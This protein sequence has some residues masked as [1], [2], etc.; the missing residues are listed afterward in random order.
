MALE[1]AN[2]K[3]IPPLTDLILLIG[4]PGAGKSTFARKLIEQQSLDSAAHISNDDIAKELFGVT[5]DRGDKD[6][7]VF[8]EQDKRIA[9]RLK[10]GQVAIVDATN[11]KPEAR[12]RLIAIAKQYN[13][14]VTALCFY[15]D[16]AT[17]LKQ[18]QGR[19]VTVPE[20]MVREYAA[21]MEK[22][23][24]D[25]LKSEGIGAVYEVPAFQQGETK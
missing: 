1:K 7:A 3:T 11:V 12:K 4:P 14:P 10:N 20:S 8:A 9:N 19:D 23:T 5:V 18:N 24:E 15:R 21:L 13:Q 17:L 6:G 22:V 25:K 2:L 16:E